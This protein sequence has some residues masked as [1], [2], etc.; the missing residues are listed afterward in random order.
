[1]NG[2]TDNPGSLL[3]NINETNGI[4]RYIMSD[5]DDSDTDDIFDSVMRILIFT[6]IIEPMFTDINTRDPMDIAIQRSMDDYKLLR[7]PDVSIRLDA[8]Q[9]CESDTCTICTICISD[10]SKG[11]MV[12]ELPCKH[13]FHA[14]CIEE[15]IK[16]KPECPL[17]KNAVPVT[18]FISDE[19]NNNSN[20]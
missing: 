12:H 7:K 10:Y 11:D 1:M 20:K 19:K 3:G 6:S 9:C 13:V 8:R 18:Q 5:L 14:Q 4:I 15:W 2:M 17:C 16:Y